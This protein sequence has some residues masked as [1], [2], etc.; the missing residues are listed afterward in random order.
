MGQTIRYTNKFLDCDLTSE[1][2][3]AYRRILGQEPKDRVRVEVM[4]ERDLLEAGD[5]RPR[6]GALSDHVNM[7]L[8]QV[9]IQ[10]GQ[11]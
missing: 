4:I 9:L 3:L 5:Y 10:I 8:N 7:G 1:N 11:L 2:A 6:S